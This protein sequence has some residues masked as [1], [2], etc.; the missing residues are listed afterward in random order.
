MERTFVTP[1]SD[2][3]WLKATSGQLSEMVKVVLERL[4]AEAKATR[5]GVSVTELKKLDPTFDGPR[6]D[7][8]NLMLRV[9]GAKCRLVPM[10]D[11][12][13][14]DAQDIGLTAV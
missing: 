2:E 11:A 5:K 3:S 6:A 4:Y 1:P 9:R 7:K 8:I 12:A 10:R 13:D 14:W